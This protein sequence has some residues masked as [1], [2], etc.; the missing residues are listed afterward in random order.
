MENMES[1]A[2]NFTKAGRHTVSLVIS[3]LYTFLVSDT[4]DYLPYLL[5]SIK[6]SVRSFFPC[7]II[8]GVYDDYSYG[9][10]DKIVKIKGEV[11]RFS[12]CFKFSGLARKL[13]KTC[14]G[15]KSMKF[16]T[17][18]CEPQLNESSNDNNDNTNVSSGMYIFFL[19][20]IAAASRALFYL[21][22]RAVSLSRSH[23]SS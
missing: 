3:W 1:W 20:V 11:Y 5:V 21:G 22:K 7:K 15:N 19:K 12:T 2:C 14:R 23:L 8:G 4:S 10:D 18:L 6:G 17:P 13:D 16:Q 9:G